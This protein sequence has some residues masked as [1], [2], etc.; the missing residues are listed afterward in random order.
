MSVAKQVKAMASALAKEAERR[1]SSIFT[2]ADLDQAARRLGISTVRGLAATAGGLEDLL[3]VMRT[4]G[5][6]LLKG[7]RLYQLQTCTL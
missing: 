4:E 7:P 3:E 1:Q 2:R 6:L 5:F